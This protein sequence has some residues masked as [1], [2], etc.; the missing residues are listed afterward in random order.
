MRGEKDVEKRRVMLMLASMQMAQDKAREKLATLVNPENRQKLL[1][2]LSPE[3]AKEFNAAKDQ[4][5]REMLLR[6]WTRAAIAFNLKDDSL[7]ER[8][9]FL[10]GMNPPVSHEELQ[11]FLKSDRLGP[12]ERDR[13]ESLPPDKMEEELRALYHQQR[14]RQGFGDKFN[15]PP[16]G[17]GSG[18]GTGPGGDDRRRSEGR[19]PAD[20]LEAKLDPNGPPP[21]GTPGAPRPFRRPP[22]EDPGK[23]GEPGNPTPAK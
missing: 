5:Q 22:T 8:R 9:R 14:W 18:P 23:G 3:A 16:R 1:A 2:Q 20:E 19:P 10:M 21:R 7:F 6:D 11:R 15:G 12:K 4:G 13:L 17:P